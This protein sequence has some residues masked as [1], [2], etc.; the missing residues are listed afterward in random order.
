MYT[1]EILNEEYFTNSDAVSFHSLSIHTLLCTDSMKQIIV[2]YEAIS[3]ISTHL[4]D[5]NIL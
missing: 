5:F 4:L 2:K 1:Y 3:G